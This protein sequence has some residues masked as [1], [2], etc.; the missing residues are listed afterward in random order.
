MWEIWLNVNICAVGSAYKVTQKQGAESLYVKFHAYATL[1][2]DDMRL[3]PMAFELLS[4]PGGL[5]G[6]SLE[7]YLATGVLDVVEKLTS[8]NAPQGLIALVSKEL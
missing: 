2:G 7:C 5:V 4:E 1:H 8:M 6:S 3:L